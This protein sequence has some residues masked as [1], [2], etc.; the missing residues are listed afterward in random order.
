MKLRTCG[1]GFDHTV[2]AGSSSW[3]THEGLHFKELGQL[4]I[5]IKLYG[6]QL[7]DVGMSSCGQVVL[8]HWHG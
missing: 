3:H 4:I 5:M 8:Q 1:T 6:T 7:C 2:V